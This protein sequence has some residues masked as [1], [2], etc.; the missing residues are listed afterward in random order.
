[1]SGGRLPTGNK[2]PPRLMKYQPKE[3]RR[4]RTP[5][6]PPPM[7]EETPT[8]PTSCDRLPTL[9]PVRRSDRLPTPC[10]PSGS[11]Y[12]KIAHF[13]AHFTRTPPDA[14]T[15]G[16]LKKPL[17]GAY[18]KHRRGYPRTDTRRS[19]AQGLFRENGAL[20]K[21]VFLNI[22]CFCNFSADKKIGSNARPS[23][24][25]ADLRG[26]YSKPSSNGL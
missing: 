4:N 24:K 18:S 1:M 22:S 7:P 2:T 11:I 17:A 9:E 6:D 5:P 23:L 10:N 15:P 3:D 21:T 14:T 25:N 16:R 19:V 8:H 12:S 13:I 26:I 20:K